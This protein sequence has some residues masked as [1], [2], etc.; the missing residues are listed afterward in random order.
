MSDRVIICYANIKIM[1][2]FKNIGF[3]VILKDTWD[4]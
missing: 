1:S 2:K 4:T 3:E